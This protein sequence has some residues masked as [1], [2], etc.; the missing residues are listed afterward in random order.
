MTP[1]LEINGGLEALDA[2]F[3]ATVNVF[4]YAIMV[5]GGL[6]WAFDIN[7]LTELKQRAKMKGADELAKVIAE[8]EQG[9]KSD[10]G[11]WPAAAIAMHEEDQRKLGD[12]DAGPTAVLIKMKEET[13]MKA[14]RPAVLSTLKQELNRRR[15]G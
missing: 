14:S 8:E 5:G 4:S 15:E 10:I 9:P 11:N 7:S 2:L 6:F 12:V 13:A 1:L 3:V